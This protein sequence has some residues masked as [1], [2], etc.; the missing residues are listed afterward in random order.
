MSSGR[1]VPKWRILNGLLEL[2][3]KNNVKALKACAV[4]HYCCIDQQEEDEDDAL[5]HKR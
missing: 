2:S 1:L 4:L 3:I 5:N